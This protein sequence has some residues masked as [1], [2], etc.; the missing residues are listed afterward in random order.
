M[1]ATVNGPACAS[2]GSP[3]FEPETGG[4]LR[5]CDCGSPHAP[6]PRI[7]VEDLADAGLK[8]HITWPSPDPHQP[9]TTVLH[10]D[11]YAT[12]HLGYTPPHAI[13]DDALE[14]QPPPPQPAEHIDG[15]TG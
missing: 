8:V 7:H 1:S 14:Y 6:R 12:D 3:W 9:A 11:A 4:A 13:P 10:G 5:C 2:C 15:A